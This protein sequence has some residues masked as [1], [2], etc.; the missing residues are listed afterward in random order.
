MLEN[1]FGAFLEKM[2]LGSILLNQ[3]LW[4]FLFDPDRTVAVRAQ[5]KT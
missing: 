1:R 4:A 3:S 5:L 2:E